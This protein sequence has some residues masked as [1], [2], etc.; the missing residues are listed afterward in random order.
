MHSQLIKQNKR[1]SEFDVI[2]SC[3]AIVDC[4]TS[5]PFFFSHIP[6]PPEV[7]LSSHH[8]PHFSPITGNRIKLSA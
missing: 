2:A 6:F 8:I 5:S 1:T 3:D 7:T 4:S